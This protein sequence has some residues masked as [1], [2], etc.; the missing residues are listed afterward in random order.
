MKGFIEKV[1]KLTPEV[2]YTESAKR[3]AKGRLD[4][5]RNYVTEFLCEWNGER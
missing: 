5:A 2:F 1:L 4:Y 3:I